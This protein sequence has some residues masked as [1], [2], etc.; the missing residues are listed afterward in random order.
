VKPGQ[1]GVLGKFMEPEDIGCEK[2]M[3]KMFLVGDSHVFKY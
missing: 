1:Q 3:L 2:Q